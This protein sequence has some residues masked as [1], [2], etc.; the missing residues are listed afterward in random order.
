[1]K[2]KNNSNQLTLTR[3]FDAPVKLVW[4]AWTDPKKAA[5]G[6]D[7]EVLLSLQKVKILSLVENGSTLC[8]ALMAWIIQISQLTL[9]SSPSRDLNMITVQMKTKKHYSGLM[10]YLTKLK[11]KLQWL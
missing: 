2:P 11:I 1:M 7:L 10:F 8:T 5:N 3:V 9:L 4:D 6:G